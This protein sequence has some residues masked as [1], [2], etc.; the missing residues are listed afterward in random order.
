MASPL[1]PK[2]GG[3]GGGGGGGP[4]GGRSFAAVGRRRQADEK[5]MAM[6]NDEYMR[7]HDLEMYLVE[8]LKHVSTKDTAGAAPA[9]NRHIE[10]AAEYFQAVATAG[11]YKLNSA[12][13]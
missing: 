1:A 8:A 6:S 11:L 2:D 7:T 13:P 5:R 12:D 4:G 10:A 3:N 9:P